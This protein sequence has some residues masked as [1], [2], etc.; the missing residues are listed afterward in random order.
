[1]TKKILVVEDDEINRKFFVSLLREQGYEVVQ[2][3]DGDEAVEAITKESP[4][5]ILMD[6]V[7]PK[8]SGYEVLKACREKG[9]LVG[10]KIYALTASPEAEVREV[11]F[12]GVIT[13]PV[14]VSEFLKTV[15]KTLH[16]S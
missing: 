16:D 6:I 13:K 3:A 14:R 15:E 4:S 5:L 10:S 1:M 11:G 7:M 2:A 8:M 12:D 9:L